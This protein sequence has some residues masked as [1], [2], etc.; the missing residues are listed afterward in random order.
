MVQVLIEIDPAISTLILVH[1]FIKLL[2]NKNRKQLTVCIL[3]IIIREALTKSF[4]YEQK[5]GQV[6]TP[7]ETWLISTEIATRHVPP[8]RGR[9]FEGR[10]C[11]C[12][13]L[14]NTASQIAHFHRQLLC[15]WL[16]MKCYRKLAVLTDLLQHQSLRRDINR[17]ATCV[18]RG[19]QNF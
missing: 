13:L 11:I 5:D 12:L 10:G 15:V 3:N 9:N 7:K 1:W 2:N 4:E 19:F 6:V 8:C 17:P 16:D 18:F 14:Y